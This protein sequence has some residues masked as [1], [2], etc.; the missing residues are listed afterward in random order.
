MRKFLKPAVFLL[1]LVPFALLLIR[2][3]QNNLG[4]DPAQELSIETGEWTLRFLL[5]TL[6]LTPLRDFTGR[7]E[8]VR[9]RR[10]LGLFA[11]FYAT[12]HLLGWMTFILGFRWFAIVEELIE[13]PYI[14]VGFTSYLILFALG[15]TSPKAM[16]RKLGKNW[17]RLHRLVYLASVLGVVHLLWILRTDIGEAVLYGSIVFVLLGYRIARKLNTKKSVFG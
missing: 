8:F 12:V 11:L 7:S 16:V 13:R 4:P 2:A 15:I 9:Q 10:M 3:L 1:A 14:T 17:K 6:A 5:I